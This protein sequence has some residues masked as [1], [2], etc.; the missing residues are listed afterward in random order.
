MFEHDLFSLLVGNYTS[1]SIFTEV[2]Y[3]KYLYRLFTPVTPVTDH[4]MRENNGQL[5]LMRLR[6]NQR[7]GRLKPS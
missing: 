3:V 1:S 6:C 4:D 7:S 2:Y 5:R